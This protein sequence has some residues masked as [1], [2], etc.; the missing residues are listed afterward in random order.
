MAKSLKWLVENCQTDEYIHIPTSAPADI[1]ALREWGRLLQF[2]CVKKGKKGHWSPTKRGVEFVKNKTAMPRY[3]H[4][5]NGK[6]TKFS[7]EQTSM[8]SILNGKK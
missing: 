3:V 1:L 8:K 4:T 7:E 6:V 5:V 2:G